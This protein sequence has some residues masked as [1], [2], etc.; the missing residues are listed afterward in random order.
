MVCPRYKVNVR[1]WPVEQ[2]SGGIISVWF[3]LE[4]KGNW[5]GVY[6]LLG[7]VDDDW[8]G[9]LKPVVVRYKCRMLGPYFRVTTLMMATSNHLRC[10]LGSS[11]NPISS[12]PSGYPDHKATPYVPLPDNG[13]WKHPTHTHH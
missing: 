2:F 7:R 4:G 9:A 10:D 5:L 11:R 12:E 3:D 13:S 1:T 8:E 6:V